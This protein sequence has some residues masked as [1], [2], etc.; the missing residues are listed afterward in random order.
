MQYPDYPRHM[1]IERGTVMAKQWATKRY[2]WCTLALECC[3]DV[4]FGRLG[5]S[6]PNCDECHVYLDWKE[7]GLTKKKYGERLAGRGL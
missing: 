5:E 7:S 3:S 6:P 1:E 4:S 2:Y